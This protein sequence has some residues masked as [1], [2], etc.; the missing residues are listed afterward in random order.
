MIFHTEKYTIIIIIILNGI[1]ILAI[2]YTTF[3]IVK[4][5]L[6][7]PM[8]NIILNVTDSKIN[9]LWDLSKY[10]LI[11]FAAS[12]ISS[13]LTAFASLLQ[14]KSVSRIVGCLQYILYKKLLSIDIN[15]PNKQQLLNTVGAEL[16][17]LNRVLPTFLTST[18]NCIFMTILLQI[19]LYDI[20]GYSSFFGI[21]FVIFICLP[22]SLVAG[23]KYA[24][25]Q[26]IR[27]NV[28]AKRIQL[29]TQLIS[30]I[31]FLKTS[32]SE[33]P[34]MN[35]INEYR[36]NELKHV[37]NIHVSI[38]IMFL[39]SIITPPLMI[40]IIL[41]VYQFV[42]NNTVK[43]TTIIYLIMTAY[44]A[45]TLSRWA[46]GC[47]AS[48]GIIVLST[49]KIDEFLNKTSKISYINDNYK[50]TN[51]N[52]NQVLEINNA[53]FKWSNDFMLKDISLKI[54]K[55]KLIAIIGTVGSGKSSLIQA[56]LG[57]MKCIKGNINYN[58]N[59]N[60][61]FGYCSQTPYI[62][63]GT[64]RDNIIMNLEFNEEKYK[65]CIF[66]ADLYS[67]LKQ[68]PNGD[69]TLIGTQGV[70]ISGGQAVRICFART[71]YR[72]H[73]YDLFLFDSPLNSV[74]IFVGKHMFENGI[75]KYL[76][77]KKKKK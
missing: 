75:L 44:I 9:L 33:I 50:Q 21:V 8:L 5:Y 65:K 10:A 20:V 73:K 11:I 40:F 25:N 23:F 76:Q 63:N 56:I 29:I 38:G 69:L 46:P 35:K 72:K 53:F 37:K 7:T 48:F 39:I 57:E 42:F 2:N 54:D 22:L 74:D 64:F 68:L 28:S 26:K 66:S 49:K 59:V 36:I 27:L 4:Q 58:L 6:Y 12:E 3:I 31:R 71:L 15:E 51:T 16:A 62:E 41:M 77:L 67:D 18:S 32:A 1:S 14:A 19:L 13:I 24:K 55:G 60:N 34:L 70:N 52:C 45:Q 30:G 61:G 47:I 43:T 17:T